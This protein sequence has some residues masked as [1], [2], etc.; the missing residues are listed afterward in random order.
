MGKWAWP[1]KIMIEFGKIKTNPLPKN[2]LDFWINFMPIAVSVLFFVAASIV[3]LLF[4]ELKKE[5]QSLLALVIEKEMNEENFSVALERC[6][7][8]HYAIC[9][10][11]EKIVD[12]FGLSLFLDFSRIFVSFVAL[13]VVALQIWFISVDRVVNFVSIKQRVLNF[14]RRLLNNASALCIN[15]DRNQVLNAGQSFIFLID[16]VLN[17]LLY[18]TSTAIIYS[19]YHAANIFMIIFINL[20]ECKRIT[21]EVSIYTDIYIQPHS[22]I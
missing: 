17:D 14:N 6:R 2:P 3:K 4:S 13:F 15:A 22:A 19:F 18:A 11:S 7:R 1:E 8:R 20:I 12:L 21:N 5:W 9:S 10:L 16:P